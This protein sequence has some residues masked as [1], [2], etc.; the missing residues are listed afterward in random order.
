M[1]HDRPKERPRATRQELVD[2]LEK[3]IAND[4]RS[5]AAHL[6][7]TPLAF[8]GIRGYYAN[9]FGRTGE[10][11][12]IYYDDALFL[13]ENVKNG[14]FESFNFN[15]DPSV[16]F[17]KFVATLKA[18]EIYQCVKHQHKGQYHA[19]QIIQ[20]IVSRDGV[21]GWDI[22]RHGINFHYDAEYFSKFSLGC[23]TVPRSQ[24]LDFQSESYRLAD[25]HKLATVK[26]LLIE[27]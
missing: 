18:N 1:T 27:D 25:K 22:G 15:T 9:T 7:E 2:R 20:D 17:K 19:W 6:T 5:F 23:Q 3:V 10:N 16:T 26:Y 4:R 21:S 8:V 14:I 12:R 13:V 24:W 11:D